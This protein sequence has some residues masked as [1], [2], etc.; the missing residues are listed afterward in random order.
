MKK[1]LFG[2]KMLKLENARDEDRISFVDM[3]GKEIKDY[4]Q[5]SI[6]LYKSTIKNFIAGKNVKSDIYRAIHLYQLSAGFNGD[7]EYPFN[8]FNILEHKEVWKQWLKAFVNDEKNEGIATKG[9]YL[10]KSYY[11]ILYQYNMII[12]DTHWISDEAKVNVQKIHDLEMPSSYFYELRDLIN[13]L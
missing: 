12:E 4:T 11:Q 3:R 10:P 2:S 5:R 9:D 1:Y 13:S 8:D 6:P 7:D